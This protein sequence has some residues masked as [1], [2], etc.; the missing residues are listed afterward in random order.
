M[1]VKSIDAFPRVFG[2]G[3]REPSAILTRCQLPMFPSNSRIDIIPL[4]RP[5]TTI[6]QNRLAKM[7]PGMLK[8]RPPA[9]RRFIRKAPHRLAKLD[10]I[11]MYLVPWLVIRTD[12]RRR[13]K[14]IRQ[15]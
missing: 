3:F 9:L 11:D 12:E 1:D 10:L 2:R 14:A 8:N 13:V 7:R 15:S 6:L 5:Y 4:G